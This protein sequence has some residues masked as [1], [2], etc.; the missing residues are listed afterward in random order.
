M[1]DARLIKM[2]GIFGL[3]AAGMQIVGNGLHPPI[4]ANTV[5]SLMVIAGTSYWVPVHLLI[6]ASYFT[7]IPFVIGAAEAFSDQKSPLLRVGTVLVIVGASIGVV[8]ITTHL[9]LFRFLA[10][11]YAGSSD[12]AYQ[13]S[14]VTLYDGFWPYSVS[15]EVAHLLAIFTAGVLFG[16]EILNESVFPRWQG[17][18]G[19]A[20]GGVA[21]VGILAGKFIIGDLTGDI[22]FGVG[23]LPLV[24]WI[25]ALSLKLLRIQPET[26]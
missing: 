9:T 24:V 10:V 5:D 13:Q 19:I 2:G 23:L 20:S 18:L 22:V 7:F 8:Q 6:T 15:L 12:P 11:Q 4:P 16:I 1:R 17:Y 25:I 21:A 3:I 26:S 14:L